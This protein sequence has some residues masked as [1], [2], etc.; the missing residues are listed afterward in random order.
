MIPLLLGRTTL[1]SRPSVVGRV[2]AMIEAN[3]PHGIASAQRGMAERRDS[4]YMDVCAVP[5]AYQHWVG[6]APRQEALLI[7]LA[8]AYLS[9]KM[10]V[11]NSLVLA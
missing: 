2:R 9:R 10:L 5:C 6:A 11:D 1:E 3:S 7:R 4:T 8:R